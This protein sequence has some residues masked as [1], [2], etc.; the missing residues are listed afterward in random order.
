MPVRLFGEFGLSRTGLQ[1]VIA[2]GRTE[3]A[4]RMS[5]P[6]STGV[7]SMPAPFQRRCS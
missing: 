4:A 1:T 7:S 5:E 6:S 2:D 3:T